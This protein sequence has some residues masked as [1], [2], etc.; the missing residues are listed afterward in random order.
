METPAG[1]DIV[2]AAGNDEAVFVL[3]D[4]SVKIILSDFS[5]DRIR[6]DDLVIGDYGC[7]SARTACQLENGIAYL[8]AEGPVWLQADKEIKYLG[9]NEN[10]ICRIKDR[11]QDPELDL[12]RATAVV[13]PVKGHYRLFIPKITKSS[14]GLYNPTD[15]RTANNPYYTDDGLTLVY[16]YNNDAWFEQSG[17]NGKGGFVLFTQE[18]Q[19]LFALTA[20]AENTSE[21]VSTLEWVLY[22]ERNYPN[23]WAYADRL[24]RNGTEELRAISCAYATDWLA[25]DDANMLK[26][27]LR[28]KV[29]GLRVFDNLSVI[30]TAG[31]TSSALGSYALTVTSYKDWRTDHIHS[32]S[33]VN[34]D[35]TNLYDFM[36]CRTN[37][38]SVMKFKFTHS[39]IYASPRIQALEIEAAIPFKGRMRPW[40]TP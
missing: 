8:S 15:N 9:E 35:G 28:A 30:G 18:T 32:S 27:F 21:S 16:D 31:T 19:R 7:T 10:G 38:A 26:Q 6:V 25:L 11:I 17:I 14:V 12:S 33:T 24:E 20:Y 23:L 5:N 39:N 4:N 3:K 13:D 40:S 36:K 1:D 29:Y 34:L 2:I 37:K 22:K